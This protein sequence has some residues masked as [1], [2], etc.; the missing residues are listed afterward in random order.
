MNNH[1][2]Y[3]LVPDKVKNVFE[4]LGTVQCPRGFILALP[5]QVVDDGDS[6]RSKV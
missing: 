3:T 5:R 1:P 4:M 6:R 2:S